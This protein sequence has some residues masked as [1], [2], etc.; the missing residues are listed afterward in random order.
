MFSVISQ[1]DARQIWLSFTTPECP[2]CTLAL[3]YLLR[4]RVQRWDSAVCTV[5]SARLC[6]WAAGQLTGLPRIMCCE[7]AGWLELFLETK[8]PG[9]EFNGTDPLIHSPNNSHFHLFQLKSQGLNFLQL[10]GGFQIFLPLFVFECQQTCQTCGWA[11]V[12]HSTT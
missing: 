12:H 1:R 11:Q 3:R 5:R 4:S 10:L 2:V 6:V 7:L 8:A 9:E